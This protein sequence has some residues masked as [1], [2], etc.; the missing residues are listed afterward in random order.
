VKKLTKSAL[1]LQLK[2]YRTWLRSASKKLRKKSCP[3]VIHKENY[4]EYFR[5]I[6]P[7]G[8]VKPKKNKKTAI[9]LTIPED[10]SL[11]SNT[12]EVLNIIAQLAHISTIKPINEIHIDHSK[13]YKDDLAAEILLGQAVAYTDASR[14]NKG[15]KFK[16]IGTYPNDKKKIRLINSVGIVKEIQEGSAS[17]QVKNEEDTIEKVKI[18]KRCGLMHEELDIHTGDQKGRAISGFTDHINECLDT[19]DKQM[20]PDATQELGEY[21]GEIIGNA[22]EHSGSPYWHIY[23]YLD[24]TDPEKVYSEIVI[25]SLGKSM[26]D[27][28]FEKKEVDIVFSKV[29]PYIDLHKDKRSENVL[30]TVKALQQ[31]VS[32]KRDEDITRGQGTID[33]LNFFNL[34][35]HECVKFNGNGVARLTIVTGSVKIDIDGTYLPQ[36]DQHTGEETIYFNKDNSPLLPPDSNFVSEM[37]GVSFPGTII[38]IKFPLR[39]SDLTKDSGV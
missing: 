36:I 2:R 35:S 38:A 5:E 17:N 12:E 33:L 1:F 34:I 24:H 20:T 18:Y 14:T 27:N 31:F 9:T 8:I 19:I 4:L 15:G 11:L 39:D 26:Y 37:K 16:A 21:I 30:I 23:G 10:F 32:S 22:E 13:M 25:Y 29:K 6:S 3:S 28:F 7:N